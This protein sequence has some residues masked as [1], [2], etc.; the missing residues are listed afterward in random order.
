MSLAYDMVVSG[1]LLVISVIMNRIALYLFAPG[2]ALH[3]M[4]SSATLLQGAARADL[5]YEILGIW[6]PL[7]GVLVAFAWPLVRVY[8]RQAVTAASTRP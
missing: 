8:R 7:F 1:V 2:T 5:W 6:M 3:E 4:A